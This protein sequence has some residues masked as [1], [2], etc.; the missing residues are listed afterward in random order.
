ME[1]PMS[2][3]PLLASVSDLAVGRAVQEDRGRTAE[4]FWNLPR[5]NC[6][7]FAV[8]GKPQS[9]RGR[10]AVRGEP[11]EDR[12]G[13]EKSV[14]VVCHRGRLAVLGKPREDCADTEFVRVWFV[15]SRTPRGPQ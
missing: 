12:V 8:L 3:E 14:V 1:V 10:L 4:S 2:P 13:T 6:G 9:L 11:R 5:L 7:R 15:P